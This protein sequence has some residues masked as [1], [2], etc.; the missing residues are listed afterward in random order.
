MRVGLVG[1]GKLGLPFALVAEAAGHDVRGTDPSETVARTLARRR[2]ERRERGLDDLLDTTRVALVPL[3]E[4]VA[5][6]ELVFVAVETPHDPAYG[7]EA[8][9]PDAARDFDYDPLTRALTQLSDAARAEGRTLPVAVISTCLPGTHERLFIDLPNLDLAYAPSFIAM[10]S[11]VE[12]LRN[13]EVL[14]IGGE[15]MTADDAE[16]VLRSMATGN[17]HVPVVRGSIASVEAAKVAYN[18][19]ISA[20]IALANLWAEICSAVGADVDVIHETW[21][22]ATRRIASPAYLWAGMSDGGGCHPRDLIALSSLTDIL[23]LPDLFRSLIRAREAHEAWL[24]GIVHEW[25]S[26]MGEGTPLVVL[27]KA[28]KPRSDLTAGSPALLLGAA[29]RDRGLTPVQSDARVD[30]SPVAMPDVAAV[31]VVATAHPEYVEIATALAPGSVVIDPF[32]LVNAAEGVAVI[33]PGRRAIG[34]VWAEIA[35]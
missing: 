3:G 8:P 7:G 16:R 13:P 31:V 20:K 1:M 2:T 24:A 11:V 9:M 30:G 33:R 19:L 27:G 32:G 34:P 10:G 18:T 21:A 5:W 17:P 14:I 6:A 15:S 4:L 28:Y 25:V 26:T 12:D 23:G 35:P 29:L 22:N